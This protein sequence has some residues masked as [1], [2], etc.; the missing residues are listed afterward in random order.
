ME[1]RG[2]WKSL[3][4]FS[5]ADV[6]DLECSL[7][8]SPR[9]LEVS[10]IYEELQP[11]ALHSSDRL[12]PSFGC[13][14]SCPLGASALISGC[15]LLWNILVLVCTW[16]S[17]WRIH[18]ILGNK[19]LRCKNVSVSHSLS[20]DELEDLVFPFSLAGWSSTVDSCCSGILCW[21]DL[22]LWLEFQGLNRHSQLYPLKLLAQF[23]WPRQDDW[24]WSLNICLCELAFCRL[25]PLCFLLEV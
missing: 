4:C 19:V 22:F 1:G 6:V 23:F 25:L 7:T 20:Q 5:M 15:W 2:W 3:Q 17:S 8:L 14:R 12:D 10:P 18:S 13:W 9:A 21:G 16:R 11:T 24:S